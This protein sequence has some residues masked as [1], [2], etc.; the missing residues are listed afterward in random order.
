MKSLHD[1]TLE[2][3]TYK[4]RVCR[5]KTGKNA[6]DFNVMKSVNLIKLVCWLMQ[7]KKRII[8]PH[9]PKQYLVI[10]V[11]YKWYQR[12]EKQHYDLMDSLM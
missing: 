10:W 6:F 1:K 12:E 7:H 2:G 5:N 11:C 3:M 9:F 4:L 8:I